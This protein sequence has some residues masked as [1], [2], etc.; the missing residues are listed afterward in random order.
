MNRAGILT[1]E[2]EY[3]RQLD[4]AQ[5]VGRS[6][7]TDLAVPIGRRPFA[8][9]KRGLAVDP[10]GVAGRQR[11]MGEQ[12][13][14]RHQPRLARREGLLRTL[15]TAIGRGRDLGRGHTASEQA[16]ELWF[17]VMLHEIAAS[18]ERLRESDPAPAFK[19]LARVCR[20]LGQLVQSWD[21]LSTLTPAD[22]LAFRDR[23]GRASGLQSHQY[24]LLEFALG[25]KNEAFVEPFRHDPPVAARLDTALATPSLYDEAIR[26]L[27]R[28]GLAIAAACIERDVSRPYR[29]HA[30]VEA[31]WQTVYEDVERHWD[32]YEL[33]EKLFDVEDLFQQW[34]FRHVM[35]VERVIGGKR[36]T[37]GSSGV[38]YLR[39]ALEHRFFPELWAVRTIL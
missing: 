11:D 9:A 33:A 6:A 13:L 14:D 37:G 2:R 38:S 8:A 23:L 21:V 39:G 12:R 29:A 16:S 19:M 31:A 27:A 10:G 32:L 28:R 26:L 17:K 7:G 25:R 30:S 4:G 3:P 35:T 18:T 5:P 1:V 24:R 22:Y 20:I 36:G 34:R 15:G